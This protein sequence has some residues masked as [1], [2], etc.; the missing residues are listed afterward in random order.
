ME[1]RGKEGVNGADDLAERARALAERAEELSR[2]AAEGAAIEDELTRLEAELAAL[3][4]ERARLDGDVED[5]VSEPEEADSFRDPERHIVIRLTSLGERI[6]DLVGSVLSS[7]GGAH[8]VVEKTLLVDGT[9]SVDIESFAGS[10]SVAA[11]APGEV[12]VY[13]ERHAVDAGDLEGIAVTAI[14]SDGRVRVACTKTVGRTL[15]SW[16]RLTVSVPAGSDTRIDTKGGSI[17]VDGVGAAVRARTAGGSIKV[18]GAR[19]VADVH[20]AGGSVRVD[21]HTGPVTARTAGGSIRVEGELSPEV[22]AETI[23]GSVKVIGV[24]GQVRAVTKGGSIQVSGR[25][26]GASEIST[27]GGSIVVGLQRGSRI[28]VDASTTGGATSDIDGLVVHDRRRIEGT[29]EGGGDGHL[30]VRTVGGGL[31]IRRD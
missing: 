25:I 1:E 11:G 12:S 16:V 27:A 31:K 14:Q 28:T 24:D 13:A 7:V 21:G 4:E 22:D 3:D 26:S 6:G 2:Q 17:D 20:T 15:R 23:G 5:L 9:P 18:S 30:V 10:V 19:G 29:I 8:D